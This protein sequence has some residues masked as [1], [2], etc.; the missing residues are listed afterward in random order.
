MP[1]LKGTVEGMNREVESMFLTELR[2]FA[3]QPCPGKRSS[4]PKDEAP[5]S[6][7]RSQPGC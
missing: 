1:H 2:G 6:F 4:Q 5:L 7:E 3:R